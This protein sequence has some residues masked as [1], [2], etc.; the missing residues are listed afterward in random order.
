MQFLYQGIIGAVV[1]FIGNYIPMVK[2]NQSTI[3]NVA[4]GLVGSLG[5]NAATSAAGVGD[6]GIL[7]TV[8]SGAGGSI[9]ALLAGKLFG[10]KAA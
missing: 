8:L 4:L 2:N 10:Q 6:G 9:V 5:G 1:G 3:T 7:S